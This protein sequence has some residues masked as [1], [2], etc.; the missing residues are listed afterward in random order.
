[1][2]ELI[3]KRDL[4]QEQLPLN[5]LIHLEIV[6]KRGKLSVLRFH[7]YMRFVRCHNSVVAKPAKLRRWA[8]L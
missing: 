8:V 7:D 3:K 1:M 6:S 5:D 2:V 4:E